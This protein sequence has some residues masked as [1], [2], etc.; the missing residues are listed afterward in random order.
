MIASTSAP[1]P[2]D[3]DATILV[4]SNLS[5]SSFLN[6]KRR[7]PFLTSAADISDADIKKFKGIVGEEIHILILQKN[8][9]SCRG[10]RWRIGINLQLFPP[11]SSSFMCELPTPESMKNYRWRYVVI[12]RPLDIP[13]SLGVFKEE[14]SLSEIVKKIDQLIIDLGGFKIRVIGGIWDKSIRFGVFTNTRFASDFGLKDRGL[15]RIWCFSSQILNLPLF[16]PSRRWKLAKESRQNMLY[17]LGDKFFA[18]FSFTSL[19][20]HNSNKIEMIDIY[21][22]A[23]N[24]LSFVASEIEHYNNNDIGRIFVDNVP[25][26]NSIHQEAIGEE[27]ESDQRIHLDAAESV[28]IDAL[29]MHENEM[30]A[31]DFTGD[32]PLTHENEIEAPDFTGD[33]PIHADVAGD[34]ESIAENQESIA[35]N[36]EQTELDIRVI[37]MVDLQALMFQENGV[38]GPRASYRDNNGAKHLIVLTPRVQEGVLRKTIHPLLINIILECSVLKMVFTSDEGMYSEKRE[39]VMFILDLLKAKEELNSILVDEDH[40]FILVPRLDIEGSQSSWKVSKTSFTELYQRFK[41][42]RP[43]LIPL[44]GDGNSCRGLYL[45]IDDSIAT[46]G[47]RGN[48]IHCSVHVSSSKEIGSEN[49]ACECIT[50]AETLF[51]KKPLV[52]Q[53]EFNS[54]IWRKIGALASHNSTDELLLNL[55]TNPKIVQFSSLGGGIGVSATHSN[56]ARYWNQLHDLEKPV[57]RNYE[58]SP[59]SI[60]VEITPPILTKHCPCGERQ[61]S[62]VGS[63]KVFGLEEIKYT[64]IFQYQCINKQHPVVMADGGAVFIVNTASAIC[65]YILEKIIFLVLRGTSFIDACRSETVFHNGRILPSP[66]QLRSWTIKYMVFSRLHSM[67]DLFRCPRCPIINRS[68]VTGKATDTSF[69]LRKAPVVA[70]DGK[71]CFYI[72]NKGD[73]KTFL[74]EHSQESSQFHDV[75]APGTHKLQFCFQDNFIDSKKLRTGLILSCKQKLNGLSIKEANVLSELNDVDLAANLPAAVSR[76][77]NRY[78]ATPG[79]VLIEKTIAVASF[80][81]D[82]FEADLLLISL[83]E[84]IFPVTT[85][86]VKSLPFSFFKV[87]M[88]QDDDI[89]EVLKLVCENHKAA[90]EEISTYSELSSFAVE[91]FHTPLSNPFQSGFIAFSCESY[92]PVKSLIAEESE[93]LSDACGKYFPFVKGSKR[94]Q[95]VLIYACAH[96]VP[97]GVSINAHGESTRQI[98]LQLLTTMP[99]QKYLY[100]FACGLRAS[101][102]K[103]APRETG[104]TSFLIDKWH[105]QGHSCSSLFNAGTNE[106]FEYQNSIL[107]EQLN[108]KIGCL[109]HVLMNCS[110]KTAMILLLCA[111]QQVASE[112]REKMR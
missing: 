105:A 107:S 77:F 41:I 70:A 14:L 51:I 66:Y 22:E 3:V 19:L 28:A 45:D 57:L 104:E 48:K 30:E 87:A 63:V 12:C 53:P 10:N 8:S 82:I 42:D 83:K 24:A 46:I 76:L 47:Q 101:F 61:K 16:Q 58:G 62:S 85:E 43:S 18:F 50:A 92:R 64:N 49:P 89:Q 73:S 44:N 21:E 79:P 67:W 110:R 4:S 99:S 81:L 108:S 94:C 98:A 2:P 55:Q 86:S 17:A 32:A 111:L 80:L 13:I 60:P 52:E 29:F 26:H 7:V 6:I 75:I 31:P 11:S 109:S 78:V 1:P 102:H 27:D 90:L 15:N 34:Q 95:S 33:A 23:P 106:M 38:Y 59:P 20:G 74:I 65:S 103:L 71:G 97:L 54:V 91:D 112:K 5:L 84:M 69:R 72:S 35:E 100:D 68:E 37:T 9:L 39:V 93:R 25:P 96:G 40:Y 56:V 36:Q 88:W